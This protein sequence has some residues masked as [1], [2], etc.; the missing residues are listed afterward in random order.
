VK[1]PVLF[2]NSGDDPVCKKE[3]IQISQIQNQG[4]FILLVTKK[5][6]HIEWF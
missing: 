1:I 6:G 4:N 3:N 5:G 2:I